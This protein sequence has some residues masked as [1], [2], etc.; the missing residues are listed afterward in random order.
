MKRFGVA[1]DVLGIVIAAVLLAACS[2]GSNLPSASRTIT[3]PSRTSGPS[4]GPT[5]SATRTLPT[6]TSSTQTTSTETETSTETTT[7]TSTQTS[8]QTSTATKTRTRTETVSSATSPPA[9]SQDSATAP[10][11]NGGT[12]VWPWILLL[13]IAAVVI[14]LVLRA[15]SSRAG[16]AQAHRDSIAAYTDAMALHDQAAVLPIS[17]EADHPRLLGDV[18]AAV[19]RT[20]A[21]FDALA[22]EPALHDAAA[23]IEAVRLALGDLRGA[24]GAQVAAGVVDP[25]LLRERLAALGGSLQRF[26]Q[27]VEP[28]AAG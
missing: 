28:P 21:R 16:A 12:P 25:D 14:A 19:D 9:G 8:T 22:T 2:G 6:R 13:L 3:V 15:R 11:E 5:A 27:R 20:A 4:L 23:E 7:S 1:R 18:S 26:R 17:A 10:A 24:L